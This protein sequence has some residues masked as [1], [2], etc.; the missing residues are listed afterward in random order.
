VGLKVTGACRLK[1][2]FCCE[3][4]REQEEYSSQRLIEI[5]DI[6]R[7]NGTSR[8]CFTGGDPLLYPSLLELLKHSHSI[9]FKN[10]LLT[11]DGVLLKKKYAEIIKFVE[12]VRF[13]VHGIEKAHDSVVGEAGAFAAIDEMIDVITAS[14]C[15]CYV[16]TVISASNVDQ[17]Y[18]IASW[19]FSKKVKHYYLF[20][21]MKSGR[22]DRFLN[23]YGE[24]S[25][26]NI[27]IVIES[28]KSMYSPSDMK[29]IYYDYQKKSE[30]ILVY[31]DGRIV[32]DPYPDAP[33]FQ[34]EIGNLISQSVLEIMTKFNSDP[35]NL[36]GYNAHLEVI[37]S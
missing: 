11:S 1:C 26:E 6:L 24:V 33:S 29:V 36:K 7:K 32:I 25:S 28:L 4:D 5:I 31:G 19:C 14:G 27:G 8:L 3:P 17:I 18:D 16:T 21:M 30:C 15:P 23:T 9:G 10:L 37:P 2:P 20:G 12:A 34:A 35:E 22:G 13:S